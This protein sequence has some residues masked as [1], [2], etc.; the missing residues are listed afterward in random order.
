MKWAPAEHPR[1]VE[2]SGSVEHPKSIE[3]VGG[4][5]IVKRVGTLLAPASAWLHSRIHPSQVF[6]ASELDAIALDAVFSQTAS[7]T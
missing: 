1:S 2:R 5:V 7:Q 3:I 6:S 4:S